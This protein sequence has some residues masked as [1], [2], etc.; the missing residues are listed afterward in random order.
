MLAACAARRWLA[1]SAARIKVIC[2]NDNEFGFAPACATLVSCLPALED[3]HIYGC[4]LVDQEDLGCLLEALA[5][6]THLTALGLDICVPGADEG[7]E[8]L[9]WPFPAPALAKLTSLASLMLYFYAG[10]TL[11]DVV[12]ALVPLTGLVELSIIFEVSADMHLVSA[13]LGQLKAL[14]SLTFY[15]IRACVLEAGCLNL[16]NLQS[17]D[18][19]D[20]V[21]RDADALPDVS[22]LQCLTG[23]ELSRCMGLLTLGAQLAQLPGLQR[24][25]LWQHLAPASEPPGPLRVPAD[26]GSLSATLLH[27]DISGHMGTRFPLSLTQLVALEHM[28]ARDTEFAELPA[29]ITALSRLTELVLGRMF[30]YDEDPLQL[31]GT[32]PLDVRALGD[33]SGF[34]ALR[35]LTFGFC[36]VMLCP[37]VL[38]AARHARLRSLCFYS[39]HPAPECA[40]AVLQLSRDLWRQR[41]G[42]VLMAVCEA[43]DNCGPSALEAAQGRAPCQ[44]FAA[45]LG[46]ARRV[47]W[48]MRCWA[49][50]LRRAGVRKRSRVE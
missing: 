4:L 25:V 33:L 2:N 42:S 26:M 37:S 50:A 23:L 45:D 40:P 15:R 27:L 19:W 17:L 5:C 48:A 16:P 43:V 7:Y 34:P 14:R 11:A 8:D 21:F 30:V 38:G 41:R 20:C 47:Q 39:A 22:A 28:S 32:R 49:S 24:L 3:V 44:R 12:G 6:C 46:R 31:R 29:G 13:A 9:H 1:R 35:E 18:F 36:E 10:Y